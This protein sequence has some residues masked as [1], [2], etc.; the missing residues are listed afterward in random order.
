M[1]QSSPRH[2]DIRFRVKDSQ[3]H[4]RS[5]PQACVWEYEHNGARF[6]LCVTTDLHQAA[7]IW[8][9]LEF[10]KKVQA[11]FDELHD[12]GVFS[13]HLKRGHVLFLEI[14]GDLGKCKKEPRLMVGPVPNRY[15]EEEV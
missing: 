1:F 14:V 6:V 7:T 9:L 13:T 8:S 3:Y 12:S 15:G 11:R 10:D 4:I 5:Q 2:Q